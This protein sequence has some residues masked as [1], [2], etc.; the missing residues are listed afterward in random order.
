VLLRPC[1]WTDLPFAQLQALPKDGKAV[2]S[3]ANPDDAYT[4]IPRAIRILACEQH[5]D[6]VVAR[7]QRATGSRELVGPELVIDY[8]YAEDRRDCH[9]ANAPLVIKNI[10]QTEQA[11]NISVLPLQAG[12]GV[13]DFEPELIPYIEA[14]GSKNVFAW[15]KKGSPL[16][17][18]RL[19]DFLFT[20]YKDESVEE[21]FGI[22]TFTLCIRYEGAGSTRFEISCEL[23]FRPW[24]KEVSVGRIE[25]RAISPD[26]R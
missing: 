19:P 18:R 14:A 13:L 7:S 23:L 24:K 9:D 15:I 22:K 25:R 8:K 11:Y 6:S 21:L 5:A 26:A 2:V 16:F 3:W 1:D 20:T 12:E 17:R 10:S 4:E